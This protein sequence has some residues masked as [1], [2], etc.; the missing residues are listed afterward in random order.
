MNK[1]LD[2]CDLPKLNQEAINKL[3]RSTIKLI[4]DWIEWIGN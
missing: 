1:F 4:S 3:D 2:K